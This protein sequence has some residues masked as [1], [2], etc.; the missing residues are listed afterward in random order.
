MHTN[1]QARNGLLKKRLKQLQQGLRNYQHVT[2]EKLFCNGGE[3]PQRLLQGAA[4]GMPWD[5]GWTRMTL[6]RPTPGDQPCHAVPRFH[7]V[8]STLF[9]ETRAK[10]SGTADEDMRLYIPKVDLAP[11]TPST[12]QLSWRRCTRCSS[13]HTSGS[14]QMWQEQRQYTYKHLV[15]GLCGTQDRLGSRLT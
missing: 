4:T 7:K 14:P 9:T 5:R 1:F 6:S 13:P 10:P 11:L 8:F 12:T 3:E 2:T 15:C